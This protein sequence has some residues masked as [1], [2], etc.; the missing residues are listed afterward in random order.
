MLV[1]SSSDDSSSEDTQN[2]MKPI[3]S[4]GMTCVAYQLRGRFV[5]Y[6]N[7]SNFDFYEGIW[8]KDDSGK[9]KSIEIVVDLVDSQ[10]RPVRNRTVPLKPILTYAGSGD[11]VIR[12]DILQ[13][14]PESK[15]LIN[16]TPASVKFRLNDVSKNHQRQSF[17]ILWTANTAA[18]PELHDIGPDFSTPIEVKSKRTKRM[19]EPK[20]EHDEVS[21]YIESKPKRKY[22]PSI[23]ASIVPAPTS[24][25]RRLSHTT[26]HQAVSPLT[27]TSVENMSQAMNS[28]FLWMSRVV[29]ELRVLKWREIGVE[30]G[31]DRTLYEM[32]NPNE[33]IDTLLDDYKAT[34]QPQFQSLFTATGHLNNTKDIAAAASAAKQYFRS[35]HNSSDNLKQQSQQ[36]TLHSSTY[37][38]PSSLSWNNSHHHQ[39]QADAEAEWGSMIRHIE[40][41]L[42]FIRQLVYYRLSGLVCR[43]HRATTRSRITWIQKAMSF[44]SMH[45]LSYNSISKG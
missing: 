25:S 37:D 41:S 45:H 24:S 20:I 17:S 7:H 22:E 11:I 13:I 5:N 21:S 29:E 40:V 15:L 18:D 35:H 23:E 3:I 30:R 2:R 9:D 43:H 42:G 33:I 38:R 8:Y 34:I 28:A 12:Q 32:S 36:S 1:I 10:D 19:R 26:H 44:T 16:D 14:L 39:Q 4:Q 31:S 27:R 6:E